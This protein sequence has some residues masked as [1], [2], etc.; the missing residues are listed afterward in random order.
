MRDGLIN[1][2]DEQAQYNSTDGGTGGGIA[3]GG[4][5]VLTATHTCMEQRIPT[6]QPF[7]GQSAPHCVTLGAVRV[8]TP[9]H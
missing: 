5:G 9:V 1:T 4:G 2:R 6:T 8:R 3:A 7:I